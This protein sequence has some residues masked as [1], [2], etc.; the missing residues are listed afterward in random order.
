[1]C[2][3][4]QKLYFCKNFLQMFF[5][6]PLSTHLPYILLGLAYLV[7]VSFFSLRASESPEEEAVANA[8]RHILT[9]EPALEAD[10]LALFFTEIEGLTAVSTIEGRRPTLRY[11]TETE[12]LWPSPEHRHNSHIFTY[13]AFSR[14][15]PS[16]L[17]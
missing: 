8:G 12:I 9:D 4:K 10:E 15:P 5:F 1:L 7:S 16:F 17:S 6:G 3:N 2:S 11:P 14:P 13:A